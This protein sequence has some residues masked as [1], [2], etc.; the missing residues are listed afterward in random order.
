METLQGITS[1]LPKSSE[2]SEISSETIESAKKALEE[3]PA[4]NQEP[5]AGSSITPVVVVEN[6]K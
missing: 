2:N 1:T 5:T 6:K 3:V 4:T